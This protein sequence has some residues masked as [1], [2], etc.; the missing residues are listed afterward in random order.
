[1]LRLFG[2]PRLLAKVPCT[3]QRLQQQALSSNECVCLGERERERGGEEIDSM[4]AAA[5]K[6]ERE[7][8]RPLFAF[9]M[10]AERTEWERAAMPTS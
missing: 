1:M 4:L 2:P 10:H 8:K 7:T 3:Q 9:S 6:R 5:W